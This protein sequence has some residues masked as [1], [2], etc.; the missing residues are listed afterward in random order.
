M[1]FDAAIMRRVT[2]SS[3]PRAFLS[4]RSSRALTGARRPIGIFK[5]I[6]RHGSPRHRR[7]FPADDASTARGKR[8]IVT[9]A[10]RDGRGTREQCFRE[11]FDSGTNVS[12]RREISGESYFIPY[13]SYRELRGSR[14]RPERICCSFRT[15]RTACDVID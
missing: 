10:L 11:A 15:A 5:C 4:P 13:E 3:L 12:C 8:G 1:H 6:L 2:Y 7:L 14:E 9:V